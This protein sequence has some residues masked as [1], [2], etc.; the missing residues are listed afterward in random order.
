L[1]KERIFVDLR[2]YEADPDTYRGKE[3]VIET[4]IYELAEDPS[5][6][7][8]R[9]VRFEA[10]IVHFV[11]QKPFGY[12]TWNM[13]V[14]AEG[15]VVRC[16]EDYYRREPHPRVIYLVWRASA[17]KGS[18]LVEGDFFFRADRSIPMELELTRI[19]Y[20]AHV[21]RTDIWRDYYSPGGFSGQFPGPGPSF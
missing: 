4:N 13:L 12:H 7:K 20:G 15:L 1:P 17:E 5:S 6:Y 11:R 8:G 2:T 21:I 14:G 3:V 18:V 19:E 10:P 9:W 16:Y